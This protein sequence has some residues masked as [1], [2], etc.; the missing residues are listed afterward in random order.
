M[1][2]VSLTTTYYINLDVIN[3]KIINNFTNIANSYIVNVMKDKWNC[4]YYNYINCFNLKC[5]RWDFYLVNLDQQCLEYI[6]RSYF[7]L[8]MYSKQVHLQA[9]VIQQGWVRWCCAVCVDKLGFSSLYSDE[10]LTSETSVSILSFLWCR[11]YIF[12]TKLFL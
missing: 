4:K 8:M 12:S 3:I 6:M 7:I 11:I 10:G 5:F 1:S 2:L 9:K